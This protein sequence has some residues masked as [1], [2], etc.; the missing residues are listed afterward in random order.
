[1]LGS[2]APVDVNARFGAGVRGLDTTGRSH[3]AG[4]GTLLL[5]HFPNVAARVWSERLG[6]S[7]VGHDGQPVRGPEPP[8][9]ARRGQVVS[10]D[11]GKNLKISRAM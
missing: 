10:V 5:G 1:M 3:S 7:L 9:G 2:D 11:R 8:A 6:S 4:E